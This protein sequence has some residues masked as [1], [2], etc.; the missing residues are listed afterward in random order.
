PRV[1]VMVATIGVSQLALVGQLLLPSIEHPGRYPSP[2]DRT[3]RIGT[4]TLSSEHFMIIAFVPASIVALVLFLNRT[5]YGIAIRASAVNPDRAELS[6]ISTKRVSTLVWILAGMLSTLTAIL[7]GPLRGTIVGI[8]APAVGPGLL[9]RALAAGLIGGLTSLPLALAGGVAIGMGEALLFANVADP[10][11]VDALLFVLVLVLVVIRSRGMTDEGAWSLAPRV[12]LVSERLRGRWWIDRLNLI[13]A[14]TAVL[15]AILLPIVFATASRNFLFTRVLLFAIVGLSVTVLTGWAGQLSLGQFAFAGLGAMVAVALVSR[16]VSFPIAVGY[17]TV[18]GVLAALAV[19]FPAL[20][21]RGLFLAVTTLAF[22]VAANSWIL[23]R[24]VLTDGRAVLV[25][26][27]STIFGVLDLHSQRT[28]YYVCLTVL[29]LCAFAVGRLRRTGIG[30]TIIAVRENDAAAAS[31]TVSP[32]VAKLTAFA[33]AGGLAALAGAL[34]AGLNVQFSATS[35][36]PEISLQLVAMVVIGGLGSVPGAIL[37]AVYVVGLPA[38]WGDSPTISL[39]TSGLGLLILL[40]YLPGGLLA[41]VHRARDAL[42]TFAARR[43]TSAPSARTETAEQRVPRPL[44]L[45]NAT[46]LDAAVPAVEARDI[47]VRFGGRLAL[48]HVS[49]TAQPGEV[50]GLIGSNGAGKSTLMNVISGFVTA[51]AGRVEV[52]GSD[53]TRLPAHRRAGHG[54][55]RVFQDARL[56]GDLTVRETVKVALESRERSEVVPS[57][58]GLPPSRRSEHEKSIVARDH[59]DFLGLGRYADAFMSDLSTG[60]RRIVELCCLVAQ[61]AR[62]LLLDE[63][64]AGIAQRETEAFGPLIKRIQ[65]E[66]GATILLIEHDIPLVMSISDRVYCLAAGAE[67]AEGLPDDVRRDPKVIAAYLGTDERAI[68]RS[69]TRS[70]TRAVDA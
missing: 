59:I 16:G 42:L 52:F 5:P 37:G 2:I 70:G 15:A 63:P 23:T 39:L 28:Y 51:D 53:V 24:P 11:I 36:G 48:D 62:V 45:P 56:F 34:Y 54:L 40:L 58:L 47:T 9:L 18:A 32:A 41:L 7:I 10:G 25:L 38:L 12:A 60:T 35:F 3:L 49:V 31:F 30:R 6:G 27:R 8:P 46:A 67:I 68:A 22:A 61:N 57:M 26:P 44:R 43:T 17:A 50:V 13:T 29:V 19:G 4:L 55:G 1:V 69:G 20:R 66:L 14:A 64:T 33:V 21:A 65:A